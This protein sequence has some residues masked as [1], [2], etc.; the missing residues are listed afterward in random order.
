LSL[1]NILVSSVP[2]VV[3]AH[4]IACTIHAKIRISLVFGVGTV[5]LWLGVFNHGDFNG[6][7][8]ILIQCQF[9]E[10]SGFF[11]E[12]REIYFGAKINLEV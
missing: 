6:V 10:V 4:W 3:L 2:S 1:R 8:F 12:I 11:L 9:R 7:L 5:Y